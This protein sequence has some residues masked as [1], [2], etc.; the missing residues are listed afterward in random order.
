M[1]KLTPEEQF[2]AALGAH[3]GCAKPYCLIRR[4]DKE[5]VSPRSFDMKFNRVVNEIEG[6]G[7]GKGCK[8]SDQ[9]A[10]AAI[11]SPALEVV[12]TIC[13]RPDGAPIID[14]KFNM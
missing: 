1:E 11:A 12:D 3:V 14:D 4:A 10:K 13:Y 2:Y 7:S 9:A 5:M 8:Y 6:I